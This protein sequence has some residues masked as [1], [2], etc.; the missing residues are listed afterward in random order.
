[1]YIYKQNFGSQ[2]AARYLGEKF[3]AGHRRSNTTVI[4]L[5]LQREG[6]MRSW[7]T[8]L[9]RRKRRTGLEFRVLKGWPSFARDNHLQERDLCLFK[10][11]KNE[12]PLKMMVYIIRRDK[13]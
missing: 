13:Y 6:K 8:K 9:Y 7:P 2:Y 5:V 12:E 1:L 3:A 10:L 11:E 4:S